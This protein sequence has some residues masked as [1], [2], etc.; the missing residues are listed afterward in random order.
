[1]KPGKSQGQPAKVPPRHVRPQVVNPLNL[2]PD[3]A[4]ARSVTH[5]TG[6]SNPLTFGVFWMPM[7]ELCGTR[8][9]A[10]KVA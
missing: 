10:W 4:G 3:F 2:G 1:M 9:Q 8:G 6:R 7:K 5:P